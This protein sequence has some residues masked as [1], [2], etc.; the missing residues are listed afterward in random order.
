MARRSK[1]G[2]IET[3]RAALVELLINFKGELETSD[4]RAKVKALIPVYH[5]LRDLGSS[6]IPPEE[7]SS[8]IDR[9]LFYLRKY[10]RT[11]L[12][13]DELMV[14]SGIGEWARRVRQLRVQFGWWIYSGV[15]FSTMAED[16]R[17]SGNESEIASLN[18]VLGVDPS[19]IKPDQ[20]VL[21]RPDQDLLAAYRWN[22]LNQIRKK[23]TSVVQKLIEYFRK[24]VGQEITG[25]ELKYLA[26][27]KKEWARRVRQLRTEQGWPIVTKNSGREDLAVGVYVLEEDRQAYEHDRS[28]P[29]LVRVAVLQRDRFKC[30]ECGWH[31]GMLSPDDPRKMLELHHNQHHKDKG[32]NTVD[33]LITLCNVHHDEQHRKARRP[34]R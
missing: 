10:P 4:L 23:K 18:T 13:G 27:D 8:G 24:N 34:M 26:K 32:T 2:R 33:N 20:Y 15:T 22:V 6:L 30:V 28:I 3:I 11:I 19:S 5:Q 14:L 17:E 29:D 16:A 12:E 21:M 9:I 7:A 31:R 1:Q 25:E